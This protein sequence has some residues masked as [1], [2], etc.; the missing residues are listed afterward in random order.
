MG[1]SN[2]KCHLAILAGGG[3]EPRE[4]ERG[5]RGRGEGGE[6]EGGGEPREGERGGRGRWEGGGEG[7]PKI[8]MFCS[9]FELE[10]FVRVKCHIS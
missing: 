6:G 10:P 9:R 1:V 3:G 5:G 4:G 8:G 7:I 2:E